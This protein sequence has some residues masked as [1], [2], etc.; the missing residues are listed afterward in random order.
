MAL[1]WKAGWVNALRGSNPLSSATWQADDLRGSR[2]RAVRARG[3]SL[4]STRPLQPRVRE[5]LGEDELPTGARARD[6][7]L[8]CESRPHQ[9]LAHHD[10]VDVAGGVVQQRPLGGTHQLGRSTP[11]VAA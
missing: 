6:E 3:G 9:V 2:S 4:F 7:G 11:V 8:G 1:A 10:L 5:D